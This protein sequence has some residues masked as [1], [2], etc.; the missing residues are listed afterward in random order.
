MGLTILIGFGFVLAAYLVGAVPVGYLVVRWQTGIDLRQYGS[1]STGTTNV[2]RAAGWKAAVVVFAVDL[3]KV[4]VPVLLARDLTGSE[5]LAA[6]AGV[7]G[8]AG[9]CWPA[10]NGWSGGRGATGA[11]AG[12]IVLQPYVAI[13]CL[14][15]AAGVVARTRYVS[16][17]SLLGTSAGCVVM[18]YL[19][20]TGAAPAGDI[21]FTIGAPLI[22]F[23][24]HRDNILRL[25]QGTERKF[26]PSA[27]DAPS[28]TT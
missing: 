20:A 7:A 1:G 5:W 27:A 26:R 12:I 24:R 4:M 6:A 25:I 15:V 3:L 11:L 21:I 17:G 9:H 28:R 10:Y 19:I 22:T 8:L 13:L 2:Y 18:I 23:V 16:L 14:A